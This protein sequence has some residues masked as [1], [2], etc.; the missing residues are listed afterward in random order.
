MNFDTT[1]IMAKMSE[2]K[3]CTKFDWRKEC[4]DC[5]K[6]ICIWCGV[7]HVQELNGYKCH[8]CQNKCCGRDKEECVRCSKKRCLVCTNSGDFTPL[9]W[10]CDSCSRDNSCGCG[11]DMGDGG[12][13]QCSRCS[14]MHCSNILCRGADVF[15]TTNWNHI[16]TVCAE[17]V[18]LIEAEL[19][20]PESCCALCQEQTGSN[21]GKTKFE[22]FGTI[23]CLGCLESMIRGIPKREFSD[24]ESI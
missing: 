12:M 19:P 13:S 18:I 22:L 1:N 3:C 4:M 9:G 17:D 20:S 14:R 21:D 6:Q 24:E 5:S 23:L 15:P 8:D 2:L 7:G 11:R 16:C 10:I